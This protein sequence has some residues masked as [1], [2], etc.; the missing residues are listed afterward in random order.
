MKA[1]FGLTKGLFQLSVRVIFC[2]PER[3]I[4]AGLAS[5]KKLPRPTECRS[6]GYREPN[7]VLDASR[8]ILCYRKDTRS[9]NLFNKFGINKRS[10]STVSSSDFLPCLQQ[11]IVSITGL[12]FSLSMETSRYGFEKRRKSYSM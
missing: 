11:K 9:D 6:C 1:L 2:Q 5:C 7:R 12:N 4:L 3:V 8:Y 10:F